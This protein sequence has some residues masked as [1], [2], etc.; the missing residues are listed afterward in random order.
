MP[1]W[2]PKLQ[3]LKMFETAYLK[4]DT[5]PSQLVQLTNLERL[6]LGATDCMIT[7]DVD[8]FAKFPHLTALCFGKIA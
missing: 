8:G 4:V 7:H 3:A 1:G 6:Y 5:F 2:L